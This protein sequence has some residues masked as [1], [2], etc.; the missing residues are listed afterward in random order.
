M[1]WHEVG[2]RFS[3]IQWV[4]AKGTAKHHA[5]LSM[6]PTTRKYAPSNVTSAEVENAHRPTLPVLL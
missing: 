2:S 6:S 1:S 5:V 3:N 4:D